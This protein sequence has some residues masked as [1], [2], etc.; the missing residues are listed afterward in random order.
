MGRIRVAGTGLLLVGVLGAC[1]RKSAEAKKNEVPPHI[2]ET[3]L[4]KSKIPGASAVGK[5]LQIADSAEARRR[6]EDSISR[7]RP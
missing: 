5:A 2:S 4:A 6:R 1:G 3:T 7:E